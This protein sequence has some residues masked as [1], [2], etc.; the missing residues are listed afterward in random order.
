[1]RSA[2]LLLLFLVRGAVSVCLLV[3]V[4]NGI[5]QVYAPLG[6]VMSQR[7]G[8]PTASEHQQFLRSLVHVDLSDLVTEARSGFDDLRSV[9]QRTR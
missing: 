6:D 5:Q 3:L 2:S 1:M 9:T 8:A 4:L 7:Q